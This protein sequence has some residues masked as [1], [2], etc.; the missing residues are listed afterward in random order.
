MKIEATQ[1]AEAQR[2]YGRH[3]DHKAR[4]L[5]RLCTCGMCWLLLT[6]RPEV[7]D[8][9]VSRITRKSIELLK[10]HFKDDMT[11]PDW[12]LVIKLKRVFRID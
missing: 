5:G 8:V 9:L 12:Q 1:P 4:C 3:F 6:T 2:L 11:R 10:A 7:Q